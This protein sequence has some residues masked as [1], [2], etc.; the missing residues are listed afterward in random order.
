MGLIVVIA[1]IKQWA[2]FDFSKKL[3]P[4]DALIVLMKPGLT[5]YYLKFGGFIQKCYLSFLS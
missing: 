2:L 3:L 4:F 5:C 1:V